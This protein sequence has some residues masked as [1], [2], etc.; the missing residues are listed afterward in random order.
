MDLKLLKYGYY[1]HYEGGDG[2]LYDH[3]TAYNRS[4]QYY[5]IFV[6]DDQNYY[7]LLDNNKAYSKKTGYGNTIIK[8]ECPILDIM[9]P[10]VNSGEDYDIKEILFLLPRMILSKIYETKPSISTIV[11]TNDTIA[12]IKKKAQTYVEMVFWRDDGYDCYDSDVFDVESKDPGKIDNNN[13]LY[14]KFRFIDSFNGER[15][16][17][18]YIYFGS[19]VKYDDAIAMLRDKLYSY[20]GPFVFKNPDRIILIPTKSGKPFLSTMDEDDSLALDEAIEIF[21]SHKSNT[22][23]VKELV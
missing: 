5:S 16:V 6:E 11:A 8:M 14:T 4:K 9:P 23:K 13:H 19:K 20:S 3:Y 18:P 2:S 22:D 12:I 15:R 1:Q 10:C 17:G 21:N 7:D